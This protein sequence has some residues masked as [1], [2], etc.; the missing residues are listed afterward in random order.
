[1]RRVAQAVLFVLGALALTGCGKSTPVSP[2]PSPSPGSS[3]ITITGTTSLDHPGETGRLTATATFSDNTSRDVTTEASWVGQ[4]GMIRTDG[5]GVITGIRYGVGSVS[6][7]YRSTPATVQI[8]VAPAGAFLVTGQVG[9]PGGF[10]LAQASVEFSSRSGTFKTTTGTTVEQLGYY[11]LPAAGETYMRAERDGFRAQ[12]RR[13]IVAGDAFDVNFELQ[14]LQTA[15]DLTGIYRLTVAASSSCVLPAE[16]MQRSYDARV[17]Q[18][19]EDL[20]ILLSGTA[21][22]SFGNYPGFSGS[23]TGNTVRFIVRDTYDDVYMFVERIDST[24]DLYYSGTAAGNADETRIVAAFNGKLD[25]RSGTVTV[26][27]CNATNH[28]FELTRISRD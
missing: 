21:L 28:Q 7:N 16:I 13:M 9:A 5:P 11:V 12:D 6:A 4:D 17:L 20:V 27:N 23:R 3:R 22:S 1:M 24:R 10:Q 2:T 8:R 19:Q 25:L 15:N 14:H 26:A 18:M